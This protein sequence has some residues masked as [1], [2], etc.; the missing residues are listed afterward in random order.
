MS[1]SHLADELKKGLPAP[2]YLLNYKDY[3]Y[4]PEAVRMLRES[5]GA[6]DQTF[7]FDVYDMEAAADDQPTIAEITDT[8]NM[9]SL[10]AARR[11][12]CVKNIQKL[13]KG[14]I[15]RLSKYA[16]K[17]SPSSVLFLFN[18][19]KDKAAAKSPLLFT[20]KAITLDFNDKELAAWAD[21]RLASY[22]C[23]IAKDAIALLKEICGDS[24]SKFANELDKLTLLGKKKIAMADTAEAVFGTKGYTIFQVADAI[25]RGDKA[26]AIKMYVEIRDGLDEVM[27]F[28]ALNW[29][30]KDKVR[31]N[32]PAVLR[33]YEQ[34]NDVS[35]RL[36][37]TNPKYPM[38]FLIYNLCGLFSS[39]PGR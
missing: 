23:T 3:Y 38:E 37:S 5:L 11:Y 19:L 1:L 28:G 18:Q 7:N 27:V 29:K 35:T 15:N 4:M 26:A 32:N 10:F 31:T 25:V 6:A 12:L 8:L 21:Q 16:E 9:V 33:Y 17:P 36:R 30:L 14:D 39:P 13:E 20:V 22:G 34:L 2:I 24:I